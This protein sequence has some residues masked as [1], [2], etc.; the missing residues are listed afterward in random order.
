MKIITQ[1]VEYRSD[2]AAQSTGKELQ[3]RLSPLHNE[4]CLSGQMEI[5]WRRQ[6]NFEVWIKKPPR[7]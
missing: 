6:G 4:R 1:I 3:V 7:R 5:N 2:L